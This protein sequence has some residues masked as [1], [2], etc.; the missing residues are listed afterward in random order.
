MNRLQTT[1]AYHSRWVGITNEDTGYLEIETEYQGICDGIKP[2]ISGK[3]YNIGYAS[4]YGKSC[5]LIKAAPEMYHALNEMA[6]EL[7]AIQGRSTTLKNDKYNI[8][9]TLDTL[10]E[11]FKEY[12]I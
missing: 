10:A 5:G 2:D 1:S 6:A 4:L 7:R 3:G 11:M 8:G 12:G 9:L